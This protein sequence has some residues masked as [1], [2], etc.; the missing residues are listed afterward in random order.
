M[1][2]AAK[3]VTSSARRS[4]KLP[5]RGWVRAIKLEAAPATMCNVLHQF[6][7]KCTVWRTSRRTVG[8]A[9]ELQIPDRAAASSRRTRET[10]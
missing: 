5:G 2:P 7:P 9:F 8:I 6:A 4:P 10:C 1:Q 3:G